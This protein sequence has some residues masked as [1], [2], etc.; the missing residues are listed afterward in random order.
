MKLAC[1][2]QMDRVKRIVMVKGK[3]LAQSDF[4]GHT[5][6]VDGCS[7]FLVYVFGDDI[8]KHAGA[9]DG[10]ASTPFNITLEA[11]MNVERK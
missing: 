7:A 10:L 6:I 3:V 8:G 2:R 9:A 4:S 1:V 11:E 5:L